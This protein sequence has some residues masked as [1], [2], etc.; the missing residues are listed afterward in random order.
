MRVFFG[1]VS[2]ASLLMI[3]KMSCA[4]DKVE[5]RVAIQRDLG[6]LKRSLPKNLM[7]FNKTTC[8]V[9]LL[10]QGNPRY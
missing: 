5:E 3:P 10:D 2:S 6:T 1:S 8:A 7:R 9:L 4:V